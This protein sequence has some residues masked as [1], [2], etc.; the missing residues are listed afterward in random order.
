MG[1]RIVILS[2]AVAVTVVAAPF[3]QEGNDQRLR[4]SLGDRLVGG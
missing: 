2:L 4:Q 1:M 3:A